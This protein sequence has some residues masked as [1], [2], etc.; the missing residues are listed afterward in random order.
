MDGNQLLL[1]AVTQRDEMGAINKEDGKWEEEQ[2]R[3]QSLF[4]CDS[5]ERSKRT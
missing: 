5:N 2:P 3:P 1:S 4:N